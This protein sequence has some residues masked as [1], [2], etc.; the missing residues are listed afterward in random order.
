MGFELRESEI[1]TIAHDE[2]NKYG[3][4]TE[5]IIDATPEKV[6]AVLTDFDKLAE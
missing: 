4:H 1:A 6:W 5:V 3:I 2:R